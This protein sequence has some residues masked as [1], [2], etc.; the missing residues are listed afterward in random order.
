MEIPFP[1]ALGY[2]TSQKEILQGRNRRGRRQPPSGSN[3]QQETYHHQE[4]PAKVPMKKKSKKVQPKNWT[5]PGKATNI[6]ILLKD[7]FVHME[8]GK[9]I[10]IMTESWEEIG[11]MSQEILLNLMTCQKLLK[12]MKNSNINRYFIL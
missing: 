6:H 4:T 8:Y 1:R 12:E 11:L 3:D 5:D 7:L 2:T 10:P 9:K